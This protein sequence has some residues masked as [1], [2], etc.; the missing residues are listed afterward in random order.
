MILRDVLLQKPLD[1][2]FQKLS[3]LLQTQGLYCGVSNLFYR[4]SQLHYF[5]LQTLTALNRKHPASASGPVC[6]YRDI[7]FKHIISCIPR[8]QAL[9]MVSYELHHLQQLQPG[10]QFPL[11]DTL[12]TYLECGCNLQK[13]ADKL[14]I[15]KNTA[16][17]RINHI[18]QLLN[19]DLEDINQRAQLWFSFQILDACPSQD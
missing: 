13:T 9:S 3:R 18:R 14:Y 4:F 11:A 1:S 6:F 16:L 2:L 10:Y 12:R 7:Y 19:S 5:Y 17:Y 8:E 15:H